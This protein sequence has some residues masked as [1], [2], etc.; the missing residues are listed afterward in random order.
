MDNIDKKLLELLKQNAR[1][2]FVELGSQVGLSEA[3]VRRRVKNLVDSGIIRR[4][5]IDIELQHEA[6][7]LTLVTVTP[8]ADSSEISSKIKSIHTVD[9]VYE[10]TGQHDIAILI[11]GPTISDVNNTIDQIRKMPGIGSTVTMVILRQVT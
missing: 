10:V 6:S 5:T 9:R 11:S 7:A 1:M 2:P 4:F 8:G 3:A